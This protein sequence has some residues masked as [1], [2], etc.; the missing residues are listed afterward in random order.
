M[1]YYRDTVSVDVLLYCLLHISSHEQLNR[2]HCAYSFHCFIFFWGGATLTEH[3]LQIHNMI[4][5]I[6]APKWNIVFSYVLQ[7]CCKE[8]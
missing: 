2:F 6:K 5:S 3:N 1:N 8:L 4:V 7:I